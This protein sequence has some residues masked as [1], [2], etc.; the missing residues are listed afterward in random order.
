MAHSAE[1]DLTRAAL[2][3]VFDPRKLFDTEAA[4]NVGRLRALAAVAT[5]VP[6]AIR[7]PFA[8][9]APVEVLPAFRAAMARLGEADADADLP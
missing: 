2:L 7:T 6:V 8:D 3:G 1:D 5:E 9:G 4:E